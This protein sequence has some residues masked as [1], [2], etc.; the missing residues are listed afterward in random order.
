MVEFS[1]KHRT[2]GEN[3]VDLSR[4]KVVLT[5]Q[6]Y[7]D[8]QRELEEIQ[9]I[10]RPA[11]V[12]RIREA[13]QLGDLSENFDYHDAKR[14]QGMIDGRIKELKS[15][16]GQ[17]MVVDKS[18]SDGH[19]T[20]GSTVVIKDLDEGFEET[21]SI[22]GPAESSPGDGKISHESTMGGAL[23]GHKAGEMVSVETPAGVFR[24]EILSVT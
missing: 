14:Q 24:Y 5:R 20:V 23:M 22:V 4:Q 17:A 15:I 18:E 10:K 3:Q 16:L 13:R 1:L 19:A 6:G 11:L 9:T 21:Y 7:E 12:R 2:T 8:I